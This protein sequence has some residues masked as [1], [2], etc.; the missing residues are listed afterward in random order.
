MQD[1]DLFFEE[2]ALSE[3]DVLSASDN[4]TITNT[5][6]GY[7]I[8]HSGIDAG[9]SLTDAIQLI[10]EALQM[11]LTVRIGMAGDQ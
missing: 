9:S 1:Q 6:V 2:D 10:T 3:Q 4:Y 7:S 8:Q 11:G 5:S